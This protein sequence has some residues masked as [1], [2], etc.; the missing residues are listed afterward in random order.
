MAKNDNT[1]TLAELRDE[2]EQAETKARVAKA[3]LLA[4]AVEEAMASTKYGHLS[5]VARQAGITGQY[6]R[7]VIEAE[8]PG[9]LAEAAKE[10]EAAK[11]AAGRKPK[12]A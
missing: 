9:W 10:R 5:A 3:A 4:C 1:K 7:D 11:G 12:A 6:L 8:H 2:S